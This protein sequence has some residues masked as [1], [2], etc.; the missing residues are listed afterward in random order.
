MNDDPNLNTPSANELIL[1]SSTTTLAPIFADA[2]LT[3]QQFRSGI[4]E[5]IS[6]WLLRSPSHDTRVNYALD[7][8]Q[9]LA[10]VGIPRSQLQRL[11]TILPHHIAAWR[12]SMKARGL[13]NASIRRKQT[14]IR[15]LFSYLQR[16]GYTGG[17]PAQI[18]ARH[19]HTALGH[20]N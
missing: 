5:A 12:D 14:T 17:N 1:T 10:F 2:K 9:F 3:P 4:A 11:T 18:L 19:A 8:K 20:Q 16:Y 15:S 13:E 7:V 6:A